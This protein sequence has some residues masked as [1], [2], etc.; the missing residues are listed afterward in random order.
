MCDYAAG[1]NVIKR[2]YFFIRVS[3]LLD[4]KLNRLVYTVTTCEGVS[5]FCVRLKND[6]ASRSSR[7][8]RMKQPRN[9]KLAAASS[10]PKAKLNTPPPPPASDTQDVKYGFNNSDRAVSSFKSQENY[11]KEDSVVRSDKNDTED[12]FVRFT[13][14]FENAKANDEAKT[15]YV[16]LYDDRNYL[17]GEARARGSVCEELCLSTDRTKRCPLS[18]PFGT[19]TSEE[20]Q[21]G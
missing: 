7:S 3:L 12:V 18:G 20:M 5:F 1:P 13:S 9:A 17:R 15:D 8:G 4:P 16:G 21:G 11:S 10:I 14:D 6:L 19:I 2:M